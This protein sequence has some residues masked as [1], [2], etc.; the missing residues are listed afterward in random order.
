MAR[1]KFD[2]KQFML[3]K[4]EFV[5]LGVAGA[6][7]VVLLLLA[8]IKGLGS[9]GA[10][11][12]AAALNDNKKRAETKLRQ[13]APPDEGATIKAVS[14][15]LDAKSRP[16]VDTEAYRLATTYF[17]GQGLGDTKR[18][19]GIAAGVTAKCSANYFRISAMLDRKR[20]RDRS[21]A[22]GN[23]GAGIVLVIR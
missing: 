9:P 11:Q 19:G 18:P 10:G 12:N 16:A 1:Q 14:A 6:I 5:G 21:V 17:S 8:A 20:E 2:V 3:Q 22:R 13:D 15:S 7:V 4:G 23:I